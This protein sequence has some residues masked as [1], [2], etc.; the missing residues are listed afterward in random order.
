[1]ARVVTATKCLTFDWSNN[2]VDGPYFRSGGKGEG[3]G[4]GKARSW[5]KRLHRK[6]SRNSKVDGIT[7]VED[8]KSALSAH[9]KTRIPIVLR[10]SSFHMLRGSHLIHLERLVMLFSDCCSRRRPHGRR[11]AALSPDSLVKASMLT[12]QSSDGMAGIDDF[13]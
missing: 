13:G 10:A 2:P 8:W 3:Q 12:R 4:G 7:S 5:K 11:A 6:F 9:Q 1:M